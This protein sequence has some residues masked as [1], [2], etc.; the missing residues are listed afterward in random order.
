MDVIRDLSSLN[1]TKS[2]L[3][4]GNFDGVHLGHQHIINQVRVIAEK[5]NCAS[6]IITFAPHPK[7]FF[8]PDIDGFCLTSV[9]QKIAM[10]EECGVDTLCVIDFNEC[11]SQ[12]SAEDF[13]KNI[14]I[15]RCQMRSILLGRSC[16]FG[17]HRLGDIELLMSFSTL[18]N[19]QIINLDEFKMGDD[20]CS[21]SKVRALLKNGDIKIANKLLG[22]NYTIQGVVEVGG[23]LGKTIGFPT[24]NLN[25][26]LYIKPKTGVYCAKINHNEQYY[27]GV[28]NIGTRPTLYEEQEVILEMHIFDFSD[29]LYGEAVSVE[30][31]N[32]IRPERKFSTIGELK[33][34]IQRD[35]TLAKQC[36]A[37]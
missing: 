9:K 14:L 7:R 15:E 28:L 17:R 25:M 4:F 30:L 18:Y 34:Q 13:I 31:M 21:S 12:L 26:G 35:V 36:F 27:S 22:R 24:I 19:Y 8:N 23:R 5:Q 3:A 37:C 29:I 16:A 6:V 33:D 20:V 11:F 10:I 32:F 2:V 1:S